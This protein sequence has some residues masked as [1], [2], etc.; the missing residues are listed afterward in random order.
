MTSMKNPLENLSAEALADLAAY[1]HAFDEGATARIAA[2]FAGKIATAK[3]A[4]RDGACDRTER[5]TMPAAP[6]AA[7][8]ATAGAEDRASEATHRRTGRLVALLAAAALVVLAG[9]TYAD[10]IQELFVSYFG[11]G[12]NVAKQAQ[13]VG[14][15]ATDQGIRLDTVSVINDGDTVYLI[16]DLVD[17]TGDRLTEDLFFGDSPLSGM[18]LIGEN[19]D[20]PYGYGEETLAFDPETRTAT[21]M[22]TGEGLAS[23]ETATLSLS[24]IYTNKTDHDLVADDL[25]LADLLDRGGTF[26]PIDWN[27][28]RG[29][30]GGVSTE[31]L[32]D[33]LAA[34]EDIEEVLVRDQMHVEIPGLDTSYIS[35]IAY[36]DGFLHI[37]MNPADSVSSGWASAQLYDLIDTRTGKEVGSYYGA[38]YGSRQ[39]DGSAQAVG[40]YQEEVFRV[41]AADL[42]YLR[43][44]VFGHSF[45]TLIE[46]DWEVSF[47]V[48]DSVEILTA[49][50]RAALPGPGEGFVVNTVEVSPLSVILS[51]TYESATDPHDVQA[52]V[53]LVYR[54]GSTSE[55]GKTMSGGSSL[56]EDTKE[57]TLYFVSPIEN[58]DDVVA[59][60]IE[61]TTVDLR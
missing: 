2:R 12:S 34:P 17:A 52:A 39:V 41:D 31:F 36:R 61:G 23:G 38:R 26:E 6:T 20:G 56:N 30:S 16:V 9:F 49:E 46:G 32:S 42:P 40:D 59:L 11:G 58:F 21:L 57:G 35:N 28:E 18:R 15:T 50:T 7:L 5:S 44:H 19:A 33:G 51:F 10:R 22:V 48:P 1:E 47:T 4:Q 8:A 54:N 24:Q 29:F 53:Q 3:T 60:S 25:N 14:A 13:P 45:D 55:V 37:Q 43:L 27:A